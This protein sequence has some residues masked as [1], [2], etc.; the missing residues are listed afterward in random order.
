MCPNIGLYT[1][2]GTYTIKSFIDG[3]EAKEEI[4]EMYID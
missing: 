3:K 4:G 2:Y 1:S